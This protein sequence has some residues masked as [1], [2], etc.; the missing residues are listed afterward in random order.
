MTPILKGHLVIEAMLGKIL[1]TAGFGEKIWCWSFPKKVE[2]SIANSSMNQWVGD[3]CNDINDIRP[4]MSKLHNE[5]KINLLKYI[6]FKLSQIWKMEMPNM[7]LHGI[8]IPSKGTAKSCA[9][10]FL[11]LPLL[12]PFTPNVGRHI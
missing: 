4:C 8:I 5:I 2:Q 9:L 12:P 11:H 10:A 3:I 6:A 7:Q 1:E